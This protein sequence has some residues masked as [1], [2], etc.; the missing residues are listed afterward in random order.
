[1]ETTDSIAE[2]PALSLTAM[3]NERV[4]FK[5]PARELLHDG[6]I[7][8]QVDHDHCGTGRILE[9]PAE[10]AGALFLNF[11]LMAVRVTVNIPVDTPKG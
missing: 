5:R 9:R 8:S 4:I 2:P 3:R 7:V 10:Q 6:Q 1:M 11:R